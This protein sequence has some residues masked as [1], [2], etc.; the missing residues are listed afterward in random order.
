MHF[1]PEP[2]ADGDDLPHLGAL[3]RRIRESRGLRPTDLARACSVEVS[4]VTRLEERGSATPETF[5]RYLGA[6]RTLSPG[7]WPL[8]R[9]RLLRDLFARR[10]EVAEMQARLE[11]VRFD[12]WPSPRRTP[13]LTAALRALEAEPY[14]AILTDSLWF[15]HAANRAFFRLYSV[16]PHA[17]FLSTWPGWHILAAKF[18][19]GSPPR[20]M[21]DDHDQ[22]LG[23]DVVAFLETAAPYLF[24]AQMRR[25]L[26]RIMT[27]SREN[28][29][30]F[31]A[32]WRAATSFS[33]PFEMKSLK[34]TQ[35]FQGQPIR[36]EPTWRAFPADLNGHGRA[37]FT[38]TVITP[39]DAAAE[40]L[41]AGLRHDSRGPEVY[42]AADYDRDGD[43]HVNAWP[44]VQRDFQAQARRTEP[45]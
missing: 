20:R 22:Y 11:T 6:L 9:E 39:C 10:G 19:A 1:N 37:E 14:P 34:R 25:L 18:V 36:I 12:L 23:R 26:A 21:Y 3:C 43:F 30:D 33:L 45:A 8:H 28:G 5:D 17:P 32:W 24:T 2:A 40:Q 29:L 38:L 27:L 44:E 4:T 16:D 31:R 13:D 41:F 15:I 35:T 42:F 7:A